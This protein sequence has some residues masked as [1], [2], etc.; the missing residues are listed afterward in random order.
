MTDPF[1]DPASGAK[2]EAKNHNG[3]LLLITPQSY[4]TGIKTTFGEKDAVDC[5]IVVIDE[6]NPT[7]SE[8]IVGGR[9]F[10]GPLIAATKPF[11]GQGMV[12]GRLGQKPTDKGNPAWI[13]TDATEDDKAKARA[14]LASKAPQL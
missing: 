5:N 11:V 13:L 6:A 10:S 8:E 2:F 4:V 7:N 12:F 14:Y 1:N 3:K 9:L